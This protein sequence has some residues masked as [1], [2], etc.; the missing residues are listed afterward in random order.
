MMRLWTIQPLAVWQILER[1][2]VFHTDP[3][4]SSFKDDYPEGC[5]WIVRRLRRHAGPESEGCVLPIWAWYQWRGV[6]R[7]KPDLRAIRY[8]LEGD[9]VRLEVEVENDHVLLS[10]FHVW[11]YC[12]SYWYL[13][14]SGRDD[15]RFN[16]E[17]RLRGLNYH[18]TKPLPDAVYYARIEQSWERVFDLDWK[19]PD[20]G[21]DNE[22]R[23]VQAVF[24]ELRLE[25]VREVS[26][27]RGTWPDRKRRLL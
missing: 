4:Q 6:A 20:G 16:K 24:W 1:D 8:E 27:L 13:P 10:D 23:W 11:H 26:H 12:M 17:L 19:G 7:A 5:D 21:F 2:G 15:R 3:A 18:R 14:S 25:Q 9:W 22:T